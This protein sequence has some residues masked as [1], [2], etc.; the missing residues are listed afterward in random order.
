[1]PR[2]LAKMPYVKIFNSKGYFFFRLES[3]VVYNHY[4]FFKCISLVFNFSFKYSLTSLL[5]EKF[6]KPTLANF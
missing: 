2:P 6:R 1:M 3:L 5:E 4:R